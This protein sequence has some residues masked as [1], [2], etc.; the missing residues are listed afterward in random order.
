M[1]IISHALEQQNL[2]LL[3]TGLSRLPMLALKQILTARND[4][5]IL[6]ADAFLWNYD[7]SP[8]IN[9]GNK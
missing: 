5:H 2:F 8:K 4:S 1:N 9:D 7:T 3:R 6:H